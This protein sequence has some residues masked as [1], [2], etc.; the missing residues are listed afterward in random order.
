[1]RLGASPDRIHGRL[2]LISRSLRCQ[3]DPR[4]SALPSPLPLSLF[5]PLL[6]VL[7]FLDVCFLPYLCAQLPSAPLRSVFCP[8]LGWS[9][10]PSCIFFHLWKLL[11]NGNETGLMRRLGWACESRI[12]FVPAFSAL[13][14]ESISWDGKVGGQCLAWAV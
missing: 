3:R 13:A 11:L 2:Q 12:T 7:L 9:L 1:M 5:A 14:K 4:P 10:F 8:S 6:D